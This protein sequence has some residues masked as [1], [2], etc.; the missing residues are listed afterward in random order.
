MEL[1]YCVIDTETIPN[2]NL[3]E[4]SRPEFKESDVSIPANWKDRFKIQ[5]KID[6]A[7]AAWEAK[8]DKTMSTDP[9]LCQICVVVGC[10]F[11]E[12][13]VFAK[14]ARNEDEEYDVLHETWTWIRR[15]Y[16]DQIPIVGFNTESFDFPVLLRRSMFQDVAVSPDMLGNILRRQDYGENKHH[17]DLMKRLAFRNPFSGK[18]EVRGIDY[19]LKRFGLAGKLNGMTGA[20]V[21]PLFK[22]GKFD[23]IVEYCRDGDVMGTAAL[24]E[25][26][27]PWIWN[28]RSAK[29][30]TINQE[31]TAA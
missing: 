8:L 28:P 4:G 6:E 25:R 18:L 5:E 9:D 14:I 27:A 21:Y 23:E 7:R 29:L 20:D 15:Q 24:F 2:Q 3:P 1:R 19:H 31:R 10:T 13:E 22:A 11:P 30:E 16:L 17:V 26:T 12:K